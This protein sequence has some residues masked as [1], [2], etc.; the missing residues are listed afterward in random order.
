MPTFPQ[1]IDDLCESLGT[2]CPLA[3]LFISGG[4]GNLLDD[5]V[6][7]RTR[8]RLFPDAVRKTTGLGGNATAAAKLSCSG[9]DRWPRPATSNLVELNVGVVGALAVL[10]S[11]T[12]S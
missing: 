2:F 8:G 6:P 9:W 3:G 5:V 11:S 4:Q 12:S 10:V 1:R 7:R